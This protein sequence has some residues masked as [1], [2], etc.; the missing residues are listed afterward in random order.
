VYTAATGATYSL[1]G[2]A[3]SNTYDV[4]GAMIASHEFTDLQD[5]FACYRIEGFYS[6]YSST[7]GPGLTSVQAFTP[8]FLALNYGHNASVS[9]ANIARS[10]AA[11]ELKMNNVGSGKQTISYELPPLVI[12]A[13]GYPVYGLSTWFS[14]VAPLAAGNL[15]MMLGYL[16]VPTFASTASTQYIP[17][18]VLDFHLKVRFAQPILE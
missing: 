11:V 9:A 2:V 15:I 7:I 12:G 1:S 18:G 5:D 3:Q 14:T 10:D 13:N 4:L 16:Q 6:T 17:V 8:A